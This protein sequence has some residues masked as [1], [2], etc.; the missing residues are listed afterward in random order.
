[1]K[2]GE[3]CCQHISHIIHKVDLQSKQSSLSFTSLF[4][5]QKS[6]V[7]DFYQ[8]MATVEN[9][10]P[11]KSIKKRR[12]W[13]QIRLQL[14]PNLVCM[15]LLCRHDTSFEAS[16]RHRKKYLA[17]V[18][19]LDP[20]NTVCILSKFPFQN[21]FGAKKFLSVFKFGRF[22]IYYRDVILSQRCDTITEM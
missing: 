10:P 9:Q 21:I 20:C 6:L 2:R 5:E 17:D 14:G 12:R 13:G 1:M 3:R 7:S 8:E 18:I 22:E 4:Y 11:K 19:S 15:I 16:F